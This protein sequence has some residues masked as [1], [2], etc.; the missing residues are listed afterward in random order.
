M[1]RVFCAA[2]AVHIALMTLSQSGLTF[3]VV[4]VLKALRVLSLPQVGQ[5]GE[6]WV[7]VMPV[8]EFHS[9]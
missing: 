1:F 7:Y 5:S 8:S 9:V 4:D 3:T 6:K 2:A